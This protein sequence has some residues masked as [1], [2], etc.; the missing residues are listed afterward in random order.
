MTLQER[1]I[2]T[3]YI[4]DGTQ[5]EMFQPGSGTSIRVALSLDGSA[6]VSAFDGQMTWKWSA[7]FTADID[8]ALI[9]SFLD[10]AE[11]MG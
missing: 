8:D 6:R 10:A 5:Y 2:A 4:T 3:G 9:L 1:L 7:D 11:T